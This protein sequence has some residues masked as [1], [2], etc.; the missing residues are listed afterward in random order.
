MSEASL[1]NLPK[2]AEVI[3]HDETMR[4]LA[5]AGIGTPEKKAD[6]LVKEL[7]DLKKINSEIV[8]AIYETKTDLVS[9]GSMIYTVRKTREG[10][11]EYIRKRIFG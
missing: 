2:G 1:V 8:N 7:A 4:E 6:G 11:K 9:S 5:M 10:N 3:P